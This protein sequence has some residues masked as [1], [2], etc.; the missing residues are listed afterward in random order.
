MR[1]ANVNLSQ[2]NNTYKAALRVTPEAKNV[3]YQQGYGNT[4][5]SSQVFD[6]SMNKF[7]SM[8]YGEFP[9]AKDVF[10]DAISKKTKAVKP[11]TKA[12][13]EM[14][15][16]DKTVDFDFNIDGIKHDYS[17]RPIEEKIENE[18]NK[19]AGY[20]YDTYLYLRGLC[21]A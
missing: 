2:A 1:I 9:F 10:F 16:F 11:H 5:I 20:L 17:G 3:V 8:L 7:Q 21:G 14:R 13:H 19:Q 6:R 4:I 15:L 18:A 12:K